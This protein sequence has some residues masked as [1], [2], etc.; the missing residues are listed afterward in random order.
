MEISEVPG[1]IL[2]V[3]LIG[4]F[5]GEPVLLK[6]RIMAVLLVTTGAISRANLQSNKQTKHPTFY[7]TNALLVAQPTKQTKH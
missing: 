5:S 4:H 7:R 1:M 2:S 6:Q 3:C